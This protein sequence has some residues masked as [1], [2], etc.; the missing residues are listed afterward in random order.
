MVY[1]DEEEAK[2]PIIPPVVWIDII[3]MVVNNQLM[4]S[5]CD[6]AQRKMEME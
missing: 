5:Q 6:E 1:V 3:D 2:A 4:Q